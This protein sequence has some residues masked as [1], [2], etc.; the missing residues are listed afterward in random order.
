MFLGSPLVATC[1]SDT[2]SYRKMVGELAKMSQCLFLEESGSAADLREPMQRGCTMWLPRA[3][4]PAGHP[5]RQCLCNHATRFHSCRRS[6]SC[7]SGAVGRTW[8]RVSDRS[9][10]RECRGRFGQGSST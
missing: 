2:G 9:L 8:A 3:T 4:L 5:C 10:H 1:R 6:Q 7:L